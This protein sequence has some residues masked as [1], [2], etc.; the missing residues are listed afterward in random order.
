MLPSTVGVIDPLHSTGIAH[1]LSGV[2]RLAQIL[3][4]T[5]SE[6]RQQARIGHVFGNVVDEVLWI[7]HLVA[8]CYAA[9]RCS[10]ELFAAVTSLYF[11]AAIHSERQLASRGEFVEGFL[12]KDCAE[13]KRLAHAD[14]VAN[15]RL[16]T[17]GHR[18]REN[19]AG[20][21]LRSWL[22]YESNCSHGT[23][24]GCWI[25]GSRNRIAQFDRSEGSLRTPGPNRCRAKFKPWRRQL[26][27]L[28]GAWL[29]TR[30]IASRM[31]DDRWCVR[32]SGCQHPRSR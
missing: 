23:T 3:L 16:A 22:G 18:R 13:L 21:S 24:W 20:S 1:G 5:E 14:R 10:F 6:A 8:S 15:G 4:T 25:P 31:A 11:V 2:Q 26:A 29:A 32:R 27:T 9:Q 30:A 19:A 17:I 7:D 12:L 28:I